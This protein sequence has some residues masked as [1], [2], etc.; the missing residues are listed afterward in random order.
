M[1]GYPSRIERLAFRDDS[2]GLAV[3]CL[4]ELTVWDFGGSGPAGT[5]PASSSGHDKHIED[6][7]GDPSG[8]YIVKL[9][10]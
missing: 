10:I 8:A 3:T 4:G 9:A 1:D 6:L 2:R 7:A 5:A